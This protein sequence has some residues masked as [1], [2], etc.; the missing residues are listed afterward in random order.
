MGTTMS[1]GTQSDLQYDTL[2]RNT[3]IATPI[4]LLVPV[5]FA[6]ILSQMGAELRWSSIGFGALGWF[7][8]LFL[9]APLAAILSQTMGDPERV[10]PWIITSSGP[11]EEV[12]R[13]LLLLLVG[14]SFSDAAAIGVGWAAIEVVYTLLTGLITLNLVKRTDPEAVQARQMLE[15]QGMI[16]ETGP[17]LGIIE[18]VA[19]TALHIGFT[20]IVAWNIW[21]AIVTAIVHSA[22][23]LGTVQ[24]F[25]KRP[26]ATEL[27]LL[28]LGLA[29]FMIG[30]ALIG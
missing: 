11:I 29:T 5:A 30:Y 9:R 27:A 13:V 25:R 6:I 26:L 20:F 24:A 8:A 23:N 1:P 4:T 12:V 28:A 15:Q 22:A 17:W 10:K 18:R 7:G 3:F 21:L 16:R 2:R 19:A 14:R